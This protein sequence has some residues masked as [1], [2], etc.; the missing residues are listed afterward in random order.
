MGL[1]VPAEQMGL[2][3]LLMILPNRRSPSTCMLKREY[4][5]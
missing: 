4:V 5:T 1:Y 3:N 2:G